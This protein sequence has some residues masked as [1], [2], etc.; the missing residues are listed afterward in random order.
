IKN[1]LTQR[2]NKTTATHTSTYPAITNISKGK[3]KLNPPPKQELPRIKKECPNDCR[4]P[5][6]SPFCEGT[7]A[8]TGAPT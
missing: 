6:E 3:V 4:G 5:L 7:C 2:N 8:S 1:L